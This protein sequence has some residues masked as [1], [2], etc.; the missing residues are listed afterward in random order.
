[1]SP[2][3]GSLYT[4]TDYL[5]NL[6]TA[7]APTLTPIPLADVFYGDQQKIPRTPAVC[8]F[9]TDKMRELQ[10]A[11][12]RIHNVFEIYVHLYVFKVTDASTHWRMADHLAEALA[13]V[14]H[15][16]LT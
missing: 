6:I 10:G 9:G 2:P 11:P 7:A 5:F 12:R 1:M 16:D 13:G 3:T 8:V 4:V 14:I 15:Q